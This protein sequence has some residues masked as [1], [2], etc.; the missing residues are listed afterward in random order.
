MNIWRLVLREIR[1]R[2]LNSLFALLSVAVAVGC[3]IGALTLLKADDIRTTEILAETTQILESR[4]KDVEKAGV[5]LNDAMR[6]I[7]KGLGFNILILHKSQDRNE[8]H[9]EGVASKTMPEEHV[10]TL[11]NS[12]IM[13][14]NHLLPMISKKVQWE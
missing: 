7:T 13:T 8:L 1:H 3:L 12:K 5:E 9:V 14:V 11:A 2:M 10:N 4:K 6:K